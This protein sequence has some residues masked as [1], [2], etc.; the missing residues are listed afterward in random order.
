LKIER[1]RGGKREREK[2]IFILCCGLSLERILMQ[3]KYP[4]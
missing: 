1:E 2:E 4:V 3:L